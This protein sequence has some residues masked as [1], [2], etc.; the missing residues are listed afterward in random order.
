MT[1]L[2]ILSST[3]MLNN[4][5][6]FTYMLCVHVYVHVCCHSCCMGWQAWP[7]LTLV[8]Q[9]TSPARSVTFTHCI[10]S[11]WEPPVSSS[12]Y[13]LP[14]SLA[15]HVP[16]SAGLLYFAVPPTVI[17]PCPPMAVV[18]CSYF[19]IVNA[20]LERGNEHI[21]LEQSSCISKEITLV[22]HWH[23]YWSNWEHLES[24]WTVY[25]RARAKRHMCRF[26][27]QPGRTHV[28]PAGLVRS[29]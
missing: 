19:C 4:H 7:Q 5:L 21:P 8:Y 18:T 26:T 6:I 3:I 11:G 9:K 22:M 20:P 1:Y 2:L 12:S 29:P 14:G 13:K 15:T 25:P 16:A 24:D 28:S 23:P 17:S 27:Y 10:R